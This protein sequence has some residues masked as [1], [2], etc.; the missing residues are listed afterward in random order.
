MK[1]YSVEQPP[2]GPEATGPDATGPEATGPKPHW[3]LRRGVSFAISTAVL[4]GLVVIV[5]V[6]IATRG[7][8]TTS[9]PYPSAVLA[10]VP[11]PGAQAPRQG[12]IGAQLAQ[13]W[14]VNVTIEGVPIPDSQLTAG[15]RELNE[16]FF[17]PGA[18]KVIET[19]Q[20]GR[21]CVDVVA[22]SL[23]DTNSPP[24]SYGWCFSA[25]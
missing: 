13:G 3:S 21:T 2:P 25:V 10:V 4:I 15:T 22:T 16:F 23:V 11:A 1:W 5:L 9:S 8:S 6:V 24:V 18:G 17:I 19:L 14:V 20:P 7:S 12:P